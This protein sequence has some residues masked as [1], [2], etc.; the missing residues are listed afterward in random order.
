[1]N[2]SHNFIRLSILSLVFWSLSGCKYLINLGFASPQLIEINQIQLEKHQQNPITVTGK[3]AKIV[4]L[5]NS[6]AYE[7]K[8]QTGS[9]WVVTNNNLPQVGE[10]ITVEAMAEYQEIVIDSENLG[11]LY[12]REIKQITDNNESV[13]SP[14][15]SNYFP[16]DLK[17]KPTP[18]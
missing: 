1:M 2:K 12:L 16:V 7:L 3:V 4:P 13:S 15:E 5:L 9:I 11:G 8:D 17:K 14:S 10:E 18:K 6:S